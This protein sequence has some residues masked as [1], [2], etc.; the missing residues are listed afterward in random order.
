MKMRYIDFQVG[1]DPLQLG[2]AETDVPPISAKEVL[3]RVEAFGVNRAD[4]LQRQ[5]K[6]PAPPGDSEILGLEVAGI[7]QQL[8]EEVRGWELG[9]RVCGLVGGGGYAEYAVVDAE[10]LMAIPKALD[11]RQAAGI[12][13]VFLTAYQSLLLIGRLQRNERV[14]IH[15]G[16]S[17]V[18][19]AAIQL[20]RQMDCDIAVTASSK[21]KLTRC[22]EAGANILINYKEDDFAA[23]L[24]AQKWQ[25]DVIVDFIGGDYLNR[26]LAVAALDS[27]IVYLAML[28]GRYADKLDMSKLL[29]KRVSI[30]GTTLRNRDAKYKRDLVKRFVSDFHHLFESASMVPNIDTI[31]SAEHV[32]VAHQRLETNQTSGKLVCCW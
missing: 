17:G 25:A 28:G 9:D 3:V 29:A 10:Q 18:G 24:K 27:R 13:E 31:L 1:C 26:N 19:L 32:G 14:L 16:A 8:G 7:V 12:P 21:T 5:G 30:S 6:Y 11:T 22:E 2:I 23:V 15:A 20:A 4:T